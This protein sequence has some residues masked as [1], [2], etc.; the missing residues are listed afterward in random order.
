MIGNCHAE[1]ALESSLLHD[2][3]GVASHTMVLII[4]GSLGSSES[5][6]CPFKYLGKSLSGYLLQGPGLLACS[7]VGVL[8]R[9]RYGHISKAD[10]EGMFY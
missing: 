6:D 1:P 3:G 5:Y 4:Q 2:G 10:I 7:Q 8:T 9:F